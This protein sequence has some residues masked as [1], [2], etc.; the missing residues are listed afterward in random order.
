MEVRAF[1]SG[2]LCQVYNTLRQDFTTLGSY[3]GGT[4]FIFHCNSCKANSINTACT[5]QSHLQGVSSCMHII[6]HCSVLPD[7]ITLRES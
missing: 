4:Y 7:H 6:G 5:L 3:H 2:T 1:G